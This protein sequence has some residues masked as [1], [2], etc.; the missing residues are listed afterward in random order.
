MSNREKII[1]YLTINKHQ[2]CDDCIEKVC[3]VHPRQQVNQICNSLTPKI[4][5]TSN[6]ICFIC[7]KIKTTRKITENLNRLDAEDNICANIKEQALFIDKLKSIG[8]QKAGRWLNRS[9][10][11]D[12]ELEDSLASSNNVL[13]AFIVDNSIKYVGKS[14]NT[15]KQRMQQYKTPGPTQSTNIE[16]NANIKSELDLG[17]SVEIYAFV[18]LGLFSYG[19]FRINLAEGLETSIIEGLQPEWN[20]K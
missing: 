10:T 9:G 11:V 8:F 6:G 15:L 19:G 3:E 2:Y 18:D 13:Y 4:I 14:T 1:E 20:K 17:K 16:N 5:E 12:Y 7:G